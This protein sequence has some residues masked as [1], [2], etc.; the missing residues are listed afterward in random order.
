MFRNRRIVSVVV[1]LALIFSSM[2]AAGGASELSDAELRYSELSKAY[3]INSEAIELLFPRYESAEQDCIDRLSTST[4]SNDIATLQGCREALAKFQAERLQV[5]KLVDEIKSEMTLLEVKIQSLKSTGSSA[6]APVSGGTSAPI[7]GSALPSVQTSPTPSATS[8]PS[9][10]PVPLTSV[11]PTPNTTPSATPTPTAASPIAS[12]P[13]ESSTATSASKSPV[14]TVSPSPTVAKKV[15][16]TPKPI[17]KK[18]TITCVKGKVTRKVTSM[19][20]V[21][22]KGFRIKKTR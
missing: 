10:S 8:T 17:V 4:N 20:P 13:S 14:P 9:A 21:C 11:T 2:S 5:S 16:A 6:G 7:S 3:E 19:K 22:P 1:G 15:T 18:R 12:S